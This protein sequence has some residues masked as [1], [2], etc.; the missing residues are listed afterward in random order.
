MTTP[1][2][3]KLSVA[4]HALLWPLGTFLTVAGITHFASPQPFVEMVPGYLPWPLALVYLSGLAE[5][6]CGLGLLL[7]RSRRLAA[8][9][10]IALFCAVFPANLNM[11]LHQ[12]WPPSMPAWLPPPSPLG[13]WLRLPFQL[14]LIAWAYVFTRRRPP[15]GA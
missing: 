11:A 4:Q 15:P 10:A 8:W 9:G 1:M 14:V 2:P 6:A 13:L 7:P 5:A 12:Y 3:P